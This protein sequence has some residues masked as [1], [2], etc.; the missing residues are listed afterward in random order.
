LT[1]SYTAFDY[2]ATFWKTKYQKWFQFCFCKTAVHYKGG[3]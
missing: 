1:C 2:K 3:P